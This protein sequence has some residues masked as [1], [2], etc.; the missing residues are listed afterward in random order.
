MRTR[1]VSTSLL[2]AS[3]GSLFVLDARAQGLRGGDYAAPDYGNAT[4]FRV[5]ADGTRSTLHA[6]AP[7]V[8]PTGAAVDTRRDVLVTDFRAATLFRIANAGG[9][10]PVATGLSGPVRVA[11]DRNGDALVTEL[12]L[13]GL[14]RITPAGVRTVIHQGAPFQRPFGVAVD[15]D[16]TY[17]VTDDMVKA[18][19]RVTP[20]GSVS[21]IHSGLPFQLPQG[22]TVLGNGDYAVID[23]LADAVMVVPR[24]SG[25]ITTLVATPIL[26]NPCGIVEDFEGGVSV[27][28]SS[29]AGNR[30]VRVDAA[31][32]LSVI[33][34]GMPFLNL[35]GLGHAPTLVGP[36][37]GQAGQTHAFDIDLPLRAARPYLL[38]AST[39]LLPG[40]SMPGLDPRQSPINPDGLFFSS[41]GANNAVFTGF[42]GLLSATGQATASLNVPAISLPQIT[43]YVQGFAVDFQSRNGI[44]ELTNVHALPF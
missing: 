25:M 17:L 43:L 40:F 41:I 27:S 33:A 22:V 36:T 35:E 26:G 16:G 13:P 9:V 23:G 30:V 34:Q 4:V 5:T 19:F 42:V 29:S 21:V 15:L 38:Y 7:L 37:Q 8:G 28:E 1:L 3:L 20:T 31:G 32:Q 11:I 44:G 2:A 12:T 14:S 6:G 24:S 10:T 18:L 39:S